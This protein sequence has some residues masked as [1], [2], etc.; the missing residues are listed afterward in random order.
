MPLDKETTRVEA[1]SDGV[2]AIAITLLALDLKRPMRYE[3]ASNSALWLEMRDAWPTFLTFFI[4]FGSVLTMWVNHHKIFEMIYKVSR[5][6]MFA[7]GLLLMLVVTV[8]FSTAVLTDYFK[9]P[10]AN[11]ATAIYAAVFALIDIA[12]CILWRVASRDQALLKPE[13]TQQHVRHLS[14]ILLAG[15]PAY[16]VAFFVSFLSYTTSLVILTVLWVYWAV[17]RKQKVL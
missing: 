17:K 4:S 14:K 9:T 15:V 6:M 16:M 5:P 11:A 1:F 3:V 13:V 8:P 10:A 2:F 7:N 12:F